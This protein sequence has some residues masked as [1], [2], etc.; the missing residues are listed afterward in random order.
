MTVI[1]QV[2]A[3]AVVAGEEAVA[4]PREVRGRRE[5]EVA[6]VVAMAGREG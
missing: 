5:L 2:Q 4:T 3:L 6:T 1:L